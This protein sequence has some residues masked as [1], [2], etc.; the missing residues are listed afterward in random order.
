M[1]YHYK[2]EAKNYNTL[3]TKN[4]TKSYKKADPNKRDTITT[5]DK[6]I[7]ENL[8]IDVRIDMSAQQNPFIAM[9]DHKPDF[10]NNSTCRL[11]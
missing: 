5:K 4:V 9:K 6:Q 2:T 7:A 10:N 3:L 11:I 1:L 8:D